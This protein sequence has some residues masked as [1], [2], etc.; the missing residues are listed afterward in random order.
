MHLRARV[1]PSPF[2]LRAQRGARQTDQLVRFGRPATLRRCCAGC[3]LNEML[4]VLARTASR[5]ARKMEHFIHE[6]GSLAR[7]L[8]FFGACGG[9]G[10]L[11]R[12]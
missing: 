8:I 3:K 7:C 6:I 12:C 1:A 10:A 5:Q 11:R 9:P 2:A 4:Q